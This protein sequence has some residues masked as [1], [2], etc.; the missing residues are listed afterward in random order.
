MNRVV[1]AEWLDELPPADRRAIGSRS[2]LRRLNF[3]MGNR[4]QMRAALRKLFPEKP[5][6]RLAELGSGD[7][8]FLLRLAKTLCRHWPNMEVTLVDRQPAISSAVKS[9]IEQCGWRATIATAD[10]FD[11]LATEQQFDCVIANLFLHHFQP[12]PLARLLAMTSRSAATFVACEPRRSPAGLVTG[13]LLWVLGCNSIT[14]HDAPI[15]VRA[16]FRERELSSLWPRN[17][18]QV[19]ESCAGLFT[20][21]FVASRIAP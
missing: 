18:W 10:V 12:G 3:C 20:H 9:R 7:G 11:W 17:Q 19:E 15:S 4:R 14:R 5:P 1:A 2:D 6:R 13:R 8:T 16:G 21:L